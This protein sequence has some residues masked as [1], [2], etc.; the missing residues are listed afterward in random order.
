MDKS[1]VVGLALGWALVSLAIILGGVGFGPYLDIPSVIIV[2]GGTSAV[3]AGQFETTDLKRMTSAMK[4]A[5]N[6]VKVEP[7]PELIEKTIFYS[8]HIF[9]FAYYT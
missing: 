7:L 1:T 9:R 2:I 5:M 4:V 6:T 8:Y 3:T